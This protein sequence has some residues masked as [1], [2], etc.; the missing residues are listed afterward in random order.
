MK[1]RITIFLAIG[2]MALGVVA[3]DREHMIRL[4]D[5]MKPKGLTLPAY[6]SGQYLTNNGTTLS[7]GAID[8][9]S[10]V[11]RDGTRTLTADWNVG[12]FD[13]TAV[14]VNATRLLVGNGS[15]ASPSITATSDTNTG[16]YFGGDENLYL[17][18]A[19]IPTAQCYG[20]N[21]FGLGTIRATN[22]L[23]STLQKITAGTG[24]GLTVDATGFVSRQVY[25]VT[26]TYAGFAAAALTAD[27]T[28]ATLPAKTK[29]VGF[30]ADTTTPFTGG[31]VTAASL[32][33]GKSAGG[34][35]YIATHDVLS[36]A[37][38]K[39]LTDADMGTELAAAALIQGG[40]V[41]NWTATTPVSARITTVTAN[42]NA[43]TAGSVTFYL[44]TERL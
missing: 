21:F 41:V 12:A 6:V 11:A 40:A 9:T 35:E 31:G 33:V 1:R 10:L 30:Y 18:S 34:V 39:G 28:I 44:I 5:L 16:I 15:S 19:G 36:G 23:E 29:I 42:T 38:T 37:V 27:H 8:T 17:V 25:K 2:L 14:D 3:Q 24:A 32:T 20:A 22:N 43:L 7:W 13:L 26:V 4:G